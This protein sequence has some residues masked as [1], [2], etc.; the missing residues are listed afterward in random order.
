M[1]PLHI[2]G[3]FAD[4]YMLKCIKLKPKHVN[5]KICGYI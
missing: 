5:Q 3:V 2:E 1:C 4:P